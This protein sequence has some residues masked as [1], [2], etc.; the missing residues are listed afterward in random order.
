M[1]GQHFWG[2]W[3]GTIGRPAGGDFSG[4]NKG[5]K[6][7]FRL[8]KG[9]KNFPKTQPLSFQMDWIGLETI[10]SGPY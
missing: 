8:K 10:V 7:F 9:A 5:A 4:K 1:L 6:Q 2:T 3:S